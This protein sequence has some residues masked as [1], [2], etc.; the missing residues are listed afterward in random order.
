MGSKSKARLEAENRALRSANRKE[1][2]VTVLLSLIRWGGVLGISYFV[3]RTVEVLAGQST[4]AEI[5]INFLGNLEVSVTL[6]WA[7]GGGG[8]LY[9][10]GQR[11]LRKDTVER[12]QSRITSL[13]K[14]LDDSRTSSKLTARGDTRP[15]DQL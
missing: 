2:I 11:K 12:L 4:F 14:K 1:S 3:F 6:A 5:G 9:G 10:L 8:V 15:E 13:E 7:A